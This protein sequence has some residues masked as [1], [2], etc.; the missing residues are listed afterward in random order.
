M[1]TSNNASSNKRSNQVTVR[2]TDFEVSFLNW[3]SKHIDV[4]RANSVRHVLAGFLADHSDLAERFL[5][6]SSENA[7]AREI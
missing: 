5:S 1:A 4:D 7:E 2:F 3:Y 6:D